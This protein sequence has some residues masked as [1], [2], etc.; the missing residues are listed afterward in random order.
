MPLIHRIP[1]FEVGDRI[2]IGNGDTGTIVACEIRGYDVKVEWDN[3]EPD[4]DLSERDRE[5]L[6][7]WGEDEVEA[8]R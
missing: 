4:D 7:W 5:G 8:I 1:K 3:K 2:R 6:Q